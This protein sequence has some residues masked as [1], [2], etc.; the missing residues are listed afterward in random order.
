MPNELV[1]VNEAPAQIEQTVE[2]QHM[3]TEYEPEQPEILA[4]ENNI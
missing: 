4:T 1:K 3:I 2:S